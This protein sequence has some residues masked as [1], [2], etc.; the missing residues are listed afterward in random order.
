ME[1]TLL[2]CD[3]AD[4]VGGKLYVMGGGWTQLLHADV[5]ASM[6]LAVLLIVS[7]NEANEGHQLD[8]ALKTEDGEIVVV[9]DQEIRQT[10]RVEVGRPPGVKPGTELNVPVALTFT[11]LVLPAGGYVWELQ[12]DGVPKAR[13]P[14]RVGPYPP[15]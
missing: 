13:A 7:W 8:A 9:G 12:I 6:A 11:G 14:F 15:E 5:P 3:A 1:A 10:G 2:L 4:N